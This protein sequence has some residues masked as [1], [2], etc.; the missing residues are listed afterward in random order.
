MCACD[1]LWKDTR[2]LLQCGGLDQEEIRM[3]GRIANQATFIVPNCRARRM[4]S[5]TFT[6][7]SFWL[8][9]EAKRA[10]AG[11]EQ[12]ERKKRARASE[13]TYSYAMDRSGGRRGRKP[14]HVRTT[15]AYGGCSTAGL[16]SDGRFRDRGSGSES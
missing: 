11:L 6:N 8:V 10:H 4:C 12:T 1:V 9:Y 7:S 14:V 16:G 13:R 2:D 15:G 3:R 5:V